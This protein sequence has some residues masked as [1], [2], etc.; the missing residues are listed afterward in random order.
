MA[1]TAMGMEVL[2]ELSPRSATAPPSTVLDDLALTIARTPVP[3]GIDGAASVGVWVGQL[4]RI[5]AAKLNYWG[6][7]ALVDDALL[8]IS[9]LVTNALKHGTGPEIRFRMVLVTNLVTDLVVLE[10]DDGSPGR[11]QVR[12]AG[13]AEESGRGMFLVASVAASWGVSED[14]TRTW[15]TLTSPSAARRGR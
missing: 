7:S 14:E 12:E 1:V 11:P 3:D 4:R 10:V 6:L 15:C 2:A 5:S 13:P 9:E 8:L